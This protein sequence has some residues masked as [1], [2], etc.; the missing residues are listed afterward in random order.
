MLRV[1]VTAP[2]DKG[3]ANEAIVR[4]L[5]GV[6]DVSRSSIELLTGQSSPR[7]RLLIRAMSAQELRRR[8]AA[9]LDEGE[10]DQE[11]SA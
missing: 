8:L 2:P 4:L 6:L 5:A 1:S 11:P 7:T 3:K 9:C 10:P